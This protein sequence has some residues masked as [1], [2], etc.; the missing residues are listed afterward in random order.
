MK[1]ELNINEIVRI[2]QMPKVFSQLEKIGKLIEKNTKDLNK[3]ECTE[4]NKQEVK[5]RRTEINNTLTLLE[6]RRK[7][8]KNKLLEPYEIFNKK[9]EEE[10]KAKL[11][12]ASNLL[13]SK[14]DTIEDEQKQQKYNELL[15]FFNQYQETY[16]LDFLKFEDIGLNI[17]LSASMTSLKAQIKDFCEKVDKDIQLIEN[18]ENKDKMMLEYLRNGYDYQKAKLT[19]IEEQ[20]QLEELKQQM[21]KKQEIEKQE[22]Q[23]VEQVQK[24]IAP[25]EIISDEELLEV[26]FTVKC[27]KE[28][29]RLL[30]RYLSD[31]EIEVI[32]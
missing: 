26:T 30:K 23:V 6:D 29:I 19:L 9:Y 2:E 13:K 32:E 18:D 15:D 28:K 25:V 24:V 21:E 11:Q 3:L 7:E 12:N 31:N 17:T 27:S 5:N 20:K 14:I 22:Q 10:C 8:I 16:H 1:E 4:E